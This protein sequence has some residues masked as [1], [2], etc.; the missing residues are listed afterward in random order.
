MPSRPRQL[1]VALFA[2]AVAAGCHHD[3]TH[4]DD[5]Q[6]MAYGVKPAVVRISAYATAEFHYDAAAIASE[7]HAAAVHRRAR[8]ARPAREGGSRQRDRA[9]ERREAAVSDA[10]VFARALRARNR[11]RAAESRASQSARIAARRFRRVA[12]R[13]I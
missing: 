9:L 10:T 7:R 11:S 2:V 12:C 5:V 4:L 6:K 13:R 1:A 3:E 8:I